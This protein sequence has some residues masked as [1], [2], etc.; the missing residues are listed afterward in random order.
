[1]NHISSGPSYDA[2]LTRLKGVGQEHVLRFYE[3]LDPEERRG[4]LEQIERLDVES[5]PRL[6]D[7]Y[8]KN[9][10]AVTLPANVEPAP[11]FPHDHLSKSR[12]WN[13]D[14]IRRKGEDLIASGRVAAFV[15]AGG[16]GS[17]LGY[18]GPKGCYPATPVT[19]KSLFQVFAEHL[20]GARQRWGVEVPWY[21]MTSPQNHEQ[22]LEFFETHTFFGLSRSSVKFFSQ[23]VMPSLDI[24]TG[25]MLLATTSH[26]ATNPDGHGGSI[27]A[28]A[29]SG[30]LEDM[31]K[32]GVEH[33]SY[34]Q[35]DNP[36]VRV[37][38]PV[39]VG[40]HAV[41]SESS[42]EMS[43]KMIPKAYPEEKMGV[44]CR[45]DGKVCVVEYSDL[46][47]SLQKERLGDGSL[48]F[49]AGSIAIHMIAVEFIDRLAHD[50]RFSLPYHRA[51]KKIPC[52]DMETGRPVSPNSNNGVKLE[53]FVFD[54]LPMCTQSIVMEVDRDEEFA[55]IKNATGVDSVESSR[56]MQTT[57]AARWL[58]TCG[59]R[60]PRKDDGSVD[61]DIEISPATATC[62]EE[63]MNAKLPAALERGARLVL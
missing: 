5:L 38:D 10:P 11:Y 25:R 4:L 60:V 2:T 16:Q 27:K 48:R 54:A 49:I 51:E 1:M 21:I 53:R 59:V 18:E 62:A 61:G 47:M 3:T 30:A 33:V 15:V 20:V 50:P 31:K 56:A 6:V 44:F 37:L 43:S 39:F 36:L 12:P 23:G 9:K 29:S 55:P 14:A 24:E 63:L 45:I 13:R 8:V 28:L 7:E 22:T 58:E 40:L 46:P 26:V 17:R 34:F 19:S 35:V 57:R 41:S 42:G 32:R 52:V